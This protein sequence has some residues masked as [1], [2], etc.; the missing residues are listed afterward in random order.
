MFRKANNPSDTWKY[1]NQLVKKNKP[2]STL[3]PTI[4]VNRITISSQQICNKMNKHF[5]QIGKKLSFKTNFHNNKIYIKFL[6]NR[7]L[8]SIF[9]RPTDEHKFFELIVDLNNRK[10]LCYIDISLILI[11]KSKSLLLQYLANSFNKYL[12]SGNYPA[13]LKIGKVVL[14]YQGGSK[15]DLNNYRP[16]SILSPINIVFETILLKRFLEF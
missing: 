11:K 7:Q 15:L 10:P 12:T 13:I 9:L 5:V 8:S 6:G 16:I 4:S 3:P 2:T 14:V 1:I